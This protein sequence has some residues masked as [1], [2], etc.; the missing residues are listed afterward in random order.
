MQTESSRLL[1]LVPAALLTVWMAV[2]QAA[3]AQTA[4]G[5]LAQ[6]E[7]ALAGGRWADAERAFRELVRQ[8]PALIDAYR[9]LAQA[10]AGLERR[11]EAAMLLGQLGEGLLG[12]GQYAAAAE[13]LAEAVA[14]DPAAVRLQGLLG[15]AHLFAQNHL[16]AIAPLERAREQGDTSA[17]TRLYLAAALWESSRP[18]EAEAIYRQLL[19]ERE[20]AFVA[21]H[22]LGRLL[23][24]Q[25]RHDEAV[26]LLRRAAALSPAAADVPYDLAQAL[27][28]AGELDEAAAAF[29][30]A[31]EASP[32]NYKA[33]YGLAR[34]LAR[35]GERDAARE[36][37]ATYQR[38]YVAE[39]QKTQRQNLE[40]ARL[41]RGWE[42]LDQKAF[43]EAAAHFASLEESSESLAGL[44][45]ACSRLG[46]HERAVRHLERAVS[47]APE[48]QDLRLMLAEE[49]LAAEGGS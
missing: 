29:R 20:G 24:W 16:A 17:A 10:L 21:V 6:G 47:L 33:H 42:L 28:A 22:Q 7:E 13:I 48:R 49:R 12:V 8:Q 27:A 37:M 11:R 44:A 40:R 9:G 25:G 36:V 2:A 31:V 18:G 32:G 34:V 45:T 38:L 46:D 1:I 43:D 19:A 35:R 15:K 39:Q 26:P 3:P 14:V 23:L 41:D 30:R 4:E 5:L